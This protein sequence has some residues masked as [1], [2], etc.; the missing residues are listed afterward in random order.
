MAYSTPKQWAHEDL[1]SGDE[2]QKYSD[3]LDA[4][5]PMFP[6]EKESWAH[7]FSLMADEQSFFLTHRCRW[8]IYKSTGVVHHPTDPVT[9]PDVSLS[10]TEPYGA[11]DLDEGVS[12]LVVGQLYQVI[13]CSVAYEDNE[14]ITV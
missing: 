3:G 9:Y 1:T 12:W 10:D 5:K 11:F 7:A 2:F 6:D 8:L 13:G 14:G 4:I